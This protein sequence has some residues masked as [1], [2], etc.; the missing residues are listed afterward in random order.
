MGWPFH[1]LY[2]IDSISANVSH[3]SAVY[4]NME[5]FG[6]LHC[7]RA[8]FSTFIQRS[9]FCI[10][11][12][13]HR[14]VFFPFF[15]FASMLITFGHR[16]GFYQNMRSRM[17]GYGNWSPRLMHY[18]YLIWIL[19][20]L[21]HFF[22]MLNAGI[23][24]HIRMHSIISPPHIVLS[25]LY[26]MYFFQYACIPWVKKKYITNEWFIDRVTVNRYIWP[27]A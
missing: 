13:Q 17:F 12:A 2:L 16:I 8:I 27:D 5:Y 14:N 4:M 11:H 22:F 26:P 19:I 9:V 20:L 23:L 10:L 15:F 21:L 18:C 1:L 25:C 3:L 24:F 7:W 6:R